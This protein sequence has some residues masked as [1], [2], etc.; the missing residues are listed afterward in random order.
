MSITPEAKIDIQGLVQRIS[1]TT[2][3][4]LEQDESARTSIIDQARSLI[5]ELETP[6]DAVTW[7]AFGEPTRRAAIFIAIQ[8]KIF[9]LL[10]VPKSAL[11]I[12]ASCGASL[13]LVKRL[14]RHLAATSVIAEIGYQTYSS[15]SL[16][17]SLCDPKHHATVTYS[18]GLTERVLGRLPAYLASTNYRDPR[19]QAPTPFQFAFE[20]KM[21]PWV[22]ARTKPEI[23][24]AFVL[25]MSGY[26]RGRPSWMDAGFYPLEGRLLSG[27]RNGDQ[28]I[29]LVDVGG[30]LGHDIEELKHKRSSLIGE[31]RLILQELLERTV[32]DAKKLRPWLEAMAYDFFTPQPIKGK[33]P[34]RKRLEREWIR[35]RPKTLRG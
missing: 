5:A 21:S 10:S 28:D 22:W 35:I 32:C 26:H 14:L 8:L 24:R 30:G 3:A 4:Y 12:A 31:R 19:G 20:T 34:E 2:R 33:V 1:D 9:P 25:S 15:T 13:P 29:L 23:A 6:N 16:S 11:E 7:L 27:C 18:A 17:R